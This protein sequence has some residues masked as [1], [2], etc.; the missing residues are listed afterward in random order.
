MASVC[1]TSA[2]IRPMAATV[3]APSM[4]SRLLLASSATDF[5]NLRFTAPRQRLYRPACSLQGRFAQKAQTD[6][7]NAK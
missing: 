2:T 7:L 1:K 5:L 6:E 3:S 4:P